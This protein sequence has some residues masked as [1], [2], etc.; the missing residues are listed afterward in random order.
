MSTKAAP[1]PRAPCRRRGRND[2]FGQSDAQ[3]P[4]RSRRT[5]PAPPQVQRAL[6]E[7]AAADGADDAAAASRASQLD[8]LDG[9]HA[10]RGDHRDAAGLG[11]PARRGNVTP[12][13]MPSRSMSCRRSRPRRRRRTAAEVERGHARNS[14]QP[15]VAT[16]PLRASMP[17]I[18]P[19]GELGAQLRDEL[20]VLHRQRAD[21]H[22]LQPA[23]S[24]SARLRASGCRRRSA[25]AGPDTPS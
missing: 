5:R 4:R 17:T 15:S 16:M 1:S 18:T 24:N 8:V 25:P 10:T 13:I 2:A 11:Q 23:S 22:P 21:D 7:R 12:C 6:V 20:R 3:P 9:G 14:A 19:A